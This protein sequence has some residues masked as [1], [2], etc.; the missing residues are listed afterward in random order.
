[1]FVTFS[2]TSFRN[3]EVG[4]GL[5][6]GS[7]GVGIGLGIAQ[8]CHSNTK[9]AIAIAIFVGLL[10]TLLPAFLRTMGKSRDLLEISNLFAALYALCAFSFPVSFLVRGETWE[11]ITPRRFG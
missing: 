11:V 5:L 2:Q 1:M 3:R 9:T 4:A 8:S 10:V 6:L 7:V